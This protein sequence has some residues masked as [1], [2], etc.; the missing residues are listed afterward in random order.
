[1]IFDD[2]KFSEDETFLVSEMFQRTPIDVW[3]KELDLPVSA[4]ADLPEG[5]LF[6]FN[7]TEAPKDL[8]EQNITGPAGSIPN[9]SSYS[10]HWSQ[11]VPLQVPGG[12]VKILDTNTFPI[13]TDFSTALVT[14]KPGAIREVQ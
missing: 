11:Q 2:G 3:A 4:F 9:E 7:G 5:D 8:A 14:I 6:I 10:Y 13:A 12:S 1:L